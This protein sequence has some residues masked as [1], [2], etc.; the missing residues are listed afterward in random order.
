MTPDQD[1]VIDSKLRGAL[2]ERFR[3]SDTEEKICEGVWGYSITKN[4]IS[5]SLHAGYQST[6]IDDGFEVDIKWLYLDK[7]HLGSR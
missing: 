7:P 6:I 2:W 4:M 3:P 5:A 1:I